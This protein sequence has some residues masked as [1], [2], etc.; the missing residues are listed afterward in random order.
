MVGGKESQNEPTY[1][2]LSFDG[3]QQLKTRMVAFF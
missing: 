3:L 1:W 2:T